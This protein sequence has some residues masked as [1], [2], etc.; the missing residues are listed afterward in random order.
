MPTGF[1]SAVEPGA[2]VRP[3]LERLR[4]LVEAEVE[5]YDGRGLT[6]HAELRA[7]RGSGGAAEMERFYW[8]MQ[9]ADPTTA[10]GYGARTLY[11]RDDPEGLRV[12]EFPS[13]PVLSWLD[14]PD[15]P[16]RRDG[17][18]EQ[19]EILR[20]IPLRRL[21]YRLLD[22]AGLPDRVIA[23]TKRTGGLNRAAVAFLA[24]NQAAAR[25]PAA[26]RVPRLLR[27]EPPRH[28]LYL[29]EL[30]GRPLHVAIAGLDLGDAMVHLGGLHR[31]L[32]ELEVKGLPV[33]RVADWLRDAREA[34][35]R[36]AMFVP[37]AAGRAE[38]IRADL[39]RKA[40]DDQGLRFCQGDFLPG[41]I[42]C[43][44]S[45]W[46]VIDLDDSRYADPLSD[47]AAM[48]V[49]MPRELRLAAVEA[50]QARRTYLDAYAARAGE[51]VDRDRWRW[52]LTLLQLN[53]LGKRLMKGRVAPGEAE[54]VLDRLVDLDDGLG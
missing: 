45:G 1:F 15:G 38:S 48:F 22:G 42:L 28:T 43:D 8:S 30:P 5:R 4:P 40:P 36:I 20:Y 11:C 6:V 33:R 16:L 21:T 27:L 10:W 46:S 52:Y 24:V 32:Q 39:A 37:S 25:R 13:E 41:Q 19:V 51:P 53:E 17:R 26:P 31:S 49:G 14:D 44:P 34:V 18:A 3:L 12:H 47:V 50:G 29:E 9:G 2:P 54:A 7:V 35:D 23:K